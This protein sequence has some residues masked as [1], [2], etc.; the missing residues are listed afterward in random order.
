VSFDESQAAAF[1]A[2]HWR[3][4]AAAGW[5]AY[6]E[7]GRGTVVVLWS[8]VESWS[9]CGAASFDIRFNT[10]SD[11]PDVRRLIVSYDP[12]ASIV[13]AFVAQGER[14]LRTSIVTRQPTPA[15]AA[16]PKES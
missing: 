2:A 16:L 5:R 9:T 10:D 15:D 6:M 7:H 12:N 3:D 13:L 1:V 14:V 8:A 11:N 4:L